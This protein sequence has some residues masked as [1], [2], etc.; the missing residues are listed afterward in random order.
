[1][2]EKYDL[3]EGRL[4]LKAASPSEQTSSHCQYTTRQLL[5]RLSNA[6]RE[7][8]RWKHTGQKIRRQ[9]S[10]TSLCSIASEE[11]I[12]ASRAV[13]TLA[14][15]LDLADDFA[16]WI[17]MPVL[18]SLRINHRLERRHWSLQQLPSPMIVIKS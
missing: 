4:H 1:M 6:E 10:S 18:Q 15:P 13:E 5:E 7:S 12:Q 3:E 9:G 14:Q 17:A 16:M 8:Q 11:G 2:D